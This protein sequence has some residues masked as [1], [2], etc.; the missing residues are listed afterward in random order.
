M[1]HARL[2]ACRCPVMARRRMLWLACGGVSLGVESV[3]WSGF[4]QRQDMN[5]KSLSWTRDLRTTGEVS[6][7]GRLSSPL[8]SASHPG[9]VFLQLPLRYPVMLL[10]LLPF[11]APAL[12][13]LPFSPHLCH[14]SACL[15]LCGP[16]S[17]PFCPVSPLHTLPVFACLPVLLALFASVT[18]C[19]LLFVPVSPLSTFPPSPFHSLL[20]ACQ[21]TD[22]LVP[23]QGPGLPDQ[24]AVP[25]QRQISLGSVWLALCP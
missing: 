22:D 21:E 17:P 11:M 25:G 7:G 13:S 2:R 12:A 10:S 14:V 16:A 18:L 9:P 5:R 1:P 15:C 6:G 19:H 4:L 23:M 8:M 20:V 3:S 24:E